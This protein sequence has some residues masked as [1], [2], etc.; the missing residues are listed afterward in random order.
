VS[1][2]APKTLNEADS[3]RILTDFDI[4]VTR[5]VSVNC[6]VDTAIAAIAAADLRFPLAV[7]V[8]STDIPHKS[9]VG[10]VRL[11]IGTEKELR[12]AILEVVEN[13]S[14]AMPDAAIEGVLV[15]EM[16]NG[17]EMLVGA[18]NDPNFGPVVTVGLGGV[19]TE[20]LRDVSFGIAPFDIDE[21]RRM[22][23]RLRS[24][25]LLESYRGRPA[26]DGEA[27]ARLV[28]DVSK[29]VVSLGDRFRELDINPVIVRH[30][31]EGVVAADAL[32][33]LR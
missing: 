14:A 30:Q 22:I 5:E 17:L 18:V 4:P 10:G 25:R 20:A 27:L 16:A 7:K 9:D 13:A 31:G 26:L 24:H 28:A 33:S 3:K 6:D 23:S 2:L 12:S 19:F 11:N 15:S 32:I 21:A 29:M 8:L 1:A